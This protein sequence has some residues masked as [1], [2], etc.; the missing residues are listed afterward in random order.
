MKLFLRIVVVLS[1]MLF[2]VLVTISIYQQLVDTPKAALVETK[3]QTEFNSLA[4]LPSSRAVKPLSSYK[5]GQAMVGCTYST[6]NSYGNIRAYYDAEFAKNGW[7]KYKEETVKYKANDYGGKVVYYRKGDYVGSLEYSGNNPN[8]NWTF[9]IY[10]SW[11]IN[12]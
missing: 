8:L 10:V 4:V 5:A 9:A 12:F 7:Q 6:D 1:V 11:G 3:L 2:L